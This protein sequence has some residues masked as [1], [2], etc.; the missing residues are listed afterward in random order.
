MMKTILRVI[1]L[2]FLLTTISIADII[3][4][5][6]DIDSI[7]GG[8][9]MA[10]EGD[11][12][13]VDVGTYYEN[14]N[15]NGKN[16]VVGSLT[17]TTGDTSFI[18]QTVIDGSQGGSLVT[19]ENGEDST[20]VLSGFTITKGGGIMFNNSN[21][22]VTYTLITNNIGA[23]RI[24]NSNAQLSHVTVKSNR[25]GIYGGN[26]TGI[27]CENSNPRLTDVEIS[28]NRG[29]NGGGISL[30]NS[31]AILMNVTVSGNISH[32]A[33]GGIFCSSS[34]P[35][36]SNVTIKGNTAGQGG[37]MYIEGSSYPNFDSVNR[38]N[39]YFNLAWTGNDLSSDDSLN[40]AIVV[41]TFTVMSPTNYSANPVESF[42]FDILNA[43]V[44]LVNSDLYVNPNG[45][46]SNSGL[47]PS[48]P[49]KTITI[50]LIKSQAD[51]LNPHTIYLAN[52][53][54]SSSTNGENYPLNMRNYV[55]L[56][57]ESETGVILDADSLNRVIECVYD[58]GTTIENLTI[59]GGYAGIG[60]GR[61]VEG[62]GGMLCW[63]SSPNLFNVTVTGNTTNTY[64]GGILLGSTNPTLSYV[65]ITNNYAG[66]LGGGIGCGNS[67]PSLSY[68]T[69]SGNTTTNYGGGIAGASGLDLSN[70]TITGNKAI[71]NTGIGGGI[72]GA[73]SS[74]I[75][76]NTILW[77]N[78]PDGMS[79][80]ED[81]EINVFYSNIQDTLWSGEGN[82][83]ADPMFVDISN[84]DYRLQSGSPCID[85][86]IQDTMIIY[87]NGQDTLIVPPITYIGSAPDIGTYEFDPTTNIKIRYNFPLN[88]SLKQNYP[89][90]FN[91]STNIEF[92]LPKSEF[93][94][95]K[96][97][98]ILGKE[99]ATLVSNRLN[100]GNHTYTFDGK[101]LA[102]G[103]YYY[104]LVAGDHREIKKMIL[105]K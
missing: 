34:S 101:D 7:Q 93:V 5:P 74:T 4:V 28:D 37:G 41:D 105:L 83:D 39:I 23:I 92:T 46:D 38:C 90:P 87:N 8:I 77:N 43:K 49:L 29:D 47:S 13:L 51:S 55:S 56:S 50:A 68:V 102:S 91:P 9:N 86:G 103:V 104:Q 60:N 66:H 73:D 97:Y 84:G 100:S 64:G 59:T 3:N 33:G 98:N 53:V 88:Y 6:A 22:R 16:I 63:Y 35:S 69:I 19:F 20:A 81:T 78:S 94:E 70:V 11:T 30:V 1:I 45:D 65:T 57:G 25:T 15:F 21:P 89:N 99:V 24:I 40:I 79:A 2:S 75:L 48:E 62:G 17:L 27:K 82:I 54:Y 80:D 95:L 76:V 44:D 96:V 72:Q 12:V 85:A 18:S 14:I 26:G 32:G 71:S 36:L 31:N 67:S 61:M 10:N 52:G 42:N 58:Q